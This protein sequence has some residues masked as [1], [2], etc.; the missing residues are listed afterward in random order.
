MD[1]T[2]E[3]PVESVEDVQDDPGA[4]SDDSH[5]GS[6][7][8]PSKEMK[9]KAGEYSV[10]PY[11]RIVVPIGKETVEAVLKG[12]T[13]LWVYQK[14]IQA[15]QTSSQSR[16]ILHWYTVPRSHIIDDWSWIA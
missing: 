10:F 12:I 6:L 13:R 9:L 7:N 14:T 4:Q 1:P 11:Y 3:E 15:T 5:K 16:A 2:D 8:E